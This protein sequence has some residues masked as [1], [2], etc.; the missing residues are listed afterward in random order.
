MLP[1]PVEAVQKHLGASAK[2]LLLDELAQLAPV[3]VEVVVFWE[4][5]LHLVA[6]C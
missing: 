5:E 4:L 6:G 2:V 3:E 1:S